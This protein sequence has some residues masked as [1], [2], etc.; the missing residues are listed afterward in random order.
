MPNLTTTAVNTTG[1]ATAANPAQH[2][3]TALQGLHQFISGINEFLVETLPIVFSNIGLNLPGEFIWFL[4]QLIIWG[5][6]VL[7]ITKKMFGRARKIG[8]LIVFALAA[9]FI[10]DFF[11]IDVTGFIAGMVGAE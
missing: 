8:L 10:L 3:I 11:G 7:F 2:L 6:T 4:A 9:M 5:P 1:N